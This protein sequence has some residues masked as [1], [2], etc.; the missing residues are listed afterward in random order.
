[1][2]VTEE[3]ESSPVYRINKFAVPAAGRE[4]FVGL[5]ER[6]HAVMRAQRGFVR[7]VIV[8]QESGGGESSFVALIEL[9]GTD[10]VERI[11]AAIA[12]RDRASGLDRKAFASRLGIRFT[13]W[14][15]AA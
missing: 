12:E 4:E 1:M 7:D 2:A 5:L 13:A 14:I 6:T 3:G 15:L 8:E 11:T 9:A 10:A